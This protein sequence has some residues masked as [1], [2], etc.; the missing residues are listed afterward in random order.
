MVPLLVSVRKVKNFKLDNRSSLIAY[1][2]K[3][4]S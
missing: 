2:V 4:Y 3:Y 1:S